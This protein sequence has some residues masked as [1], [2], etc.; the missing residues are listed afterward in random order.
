MLRHLQRPLRWLRPA[1]LPSGW[2]SRRTRRRPLSR[3]PWPT[4]ERDHPLANQPITAPPAIAA[5]RLPDKAVVSIVA[6]AAAPGP[7]TRQPR[8]SSVRFTTRNAQP[9]VIAHIQ[10]S[11]PAIAQSRIPKPSAAPDA[12]AMMAAPGVK[13]IVNTL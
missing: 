11:L 1:R 6:L 10:A 12:P 3:L 4:E 13:S 8:P 5:T 2:R 9:P 7:P